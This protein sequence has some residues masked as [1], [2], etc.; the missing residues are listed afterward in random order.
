MKTTK[1]RITWSGYGRAFVGSLYTGYQ[2]MEQDGKWQIL[3]PSGAM[4]T[5][6]SR[7]DARDWVAQQVA[8]GE[9]V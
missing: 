4:E 1:T 7:R 9:L 2:V 3:C 8:E 6:D 5:R